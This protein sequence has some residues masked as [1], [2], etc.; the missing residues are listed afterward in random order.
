M[1]EVGM[2]NNQQMDEVF[3]DPDFDS[4]NC[5]Q[6]FPS[7][8]NTLS[9]FDFGVWRKTPYLMQWKALLQFN[10]VTNNEQSEKHKYNNQSMS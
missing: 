3:H 6:L 9:K 2:M 1:D 7:L 8:E 5:K 10:S 4:D